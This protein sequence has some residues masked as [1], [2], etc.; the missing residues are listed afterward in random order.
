MNTLEIYLRGGK[1]LK[2]QVGLDA[3]QIK[4]LLFVPQ[5]DGNYFAVFEAVGASEKLINVAV[6]LSTIMA[7]TVVEVT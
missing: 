3:S 1:V 2:A 7:Y 4:K 5:D 6:R